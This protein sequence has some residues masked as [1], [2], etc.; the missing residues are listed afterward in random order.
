MGE[1][2]DKNPIDRLE[3]F[4]RRSERLLHRAALLDSSRGQNLKREAWLRRLAHYA[5]H[6]RWIA[7]HI[8][9]PVHFHQFAVQDLL[10]FLVAASAVVDAAGVEV[11]VP[12]LLFDE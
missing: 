3:A 7:L 10:P 12:T 6:P 1:Y 11:D 4:K 9:L 2:P 5:V 8:D